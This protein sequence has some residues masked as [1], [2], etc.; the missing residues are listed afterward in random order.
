MSR[1]VIR[2]SLSIS[3]A[4]GTYGA[5]F[6]VASV[7]AGLS[8]LQ[9]CALSLL[10]FSGASQFAVAGVLGAGGSALSAITASALLALRNGFYGARMAP[11][12]Q[13]RGVKRLL[14]SQIT[15]DESTAIALAH[16]QTSK[17]DARRGFWLTGGGIYLFWNLATLLGALGANALGDPAQWG[18]DA[19]IPAAFLGLLWPRLTNTRAR[20][21]AIGAV[22]LALTLTPFLSPGLPIIACVAIPIIAG[23][24]VRP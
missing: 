15:I 9:T 23:W 21:V 12:L 10:L 16:E 4:V 7:A 1:A 17:E 20:I 8:L 24:R 5:A 14:A 6:G 19:T 18:L 2:D 13:V 22:A 3:I 11:L